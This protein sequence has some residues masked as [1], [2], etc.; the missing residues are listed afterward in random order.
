MS[1]EASDERFT[2]TQVAKLLSVS[3]PTVRR[4]VFSGKLRAAK[5]LVGDKMRW[6]V[7]RD[8]AFRLQR[9]LTIGD[10]R[11]T[12]EA[13]YERAEVTEEKRSSS[14]STEENM[15]SRSVPIEAL[16]A[17]LEFA[18]RRI[19]EERHRALEA[20]DQAEQLR[21][22]LNSERSKTL[23]AERATIALETQLAQYHR[24]L[25]D[26]AESLAEERAHR[27]TAESRLEAMVIEP[28]PVPLE[29]LKTST[30]TSK[31][32]WGQRVRGWLGM[33]EAS[34]GRR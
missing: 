34:S 33:N 14:T 15:P 7:P 2:L 27:K 22:H 23:Q 26:S 16:T 25:T 24:A 12:H 9:E 29:S 32:S 28:S 19:A 3:V 30:P 10:A 5:I 17:A 13:L 8:E 31:R 18:E 1:K 11:V 21:Q 4:L 6:E 20:Q